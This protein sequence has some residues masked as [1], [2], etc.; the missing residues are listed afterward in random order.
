MLLRGIERGFPYG[1]AR[2]RD[3]A[4]DAGESVPPRR[5][6]GRRPRLIAGEHENPPRGTVLLE[7]L[8]SPANRIGLTSRTAAL[9]GKRVRRT[10]TRPVWSSSTRPE[11][12]PTWRHSEGGRCAPPVA[13]TA[14]PVCHRLRLVALGKSSG[15]PRRR[16]I[17][18][19]RRVARSSR[20]QVPAPRRSGSAII[21]DIK[22]ENWRLTAGWRSRFSNYV[23]VS[24][25]ISLPRSSPS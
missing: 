18:R 13:C 7:K 12:R 6:G 3:A 2:A 5:V 11:P 10:S 25:P 16:P 22:G 15:H 9:A 4:L 8:R 21:H 17:R 20:T 24:D 19:R 23:V 1:S 14:E